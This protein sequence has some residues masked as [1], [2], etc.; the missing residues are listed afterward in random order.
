MKRIA[1]YIVLAAIAFNSCNKK[2]DKVFDKSIDERLNETLAADQ[3]ALTGAPYGW[4]GF[5]YPAGL[6]G[7]VVAFYFKFNDS[8]RVEMFSDFD[9]ASAV[10]PMTASY[11]LK[12]LQQPSLI[13][14]TY[15]YVHVLADPDGSVNGGDYGAGLGSDFEFAID[16]MAKDSVKLTG[17]FN[18]SKAFL[19]KATQ[20]EMQSYYDKKYS[21]R[22][23]ANISKYTTYFKRLVIGSSQYEIKVDQ[24]TR[25]ITLTWV[26]D[27]GAVHSVTTGYYYTTDGIVLSP[28]IVAGANVISSLN[29]ISWSGTGPTMSFTINGTASSIVG[30]VEPINID[31][32][33]PQRW[34]QYALDQDGYW[35]SPKGF[36]VNGV[37]DAYGITKTANFYFLMYQPQRGTQSGIAYDLAGTV[38]VVN[39]ALSLPYGIAY[40]PPNFTGD[41]RVS[42]SYFGT[43]GTVPTADSIPVYKTAIQFTDAS[44]YYLV[45]IDSTHYD[46]VS[47]KDGK[48]WISW[49][50]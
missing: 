47:A 41:G 37:D 3:K 27:K 12:A 10:T 24:T 7:G 45:R 30:A 43:L 15:S 36:H 8:N 40:R 42:F 46:M 2:E 6:K 34:W 4:K 26:D 23:F 22:L 50:Y 25:T 13:F 5:I 49:Q 9:A 11:R 39:N 35:I 14:D 33:A 44:G 16:S 32:D 17:R 38:K 19:V 29:N 28:A 31:P 21:N 1:S 20:A 48:A 18:K